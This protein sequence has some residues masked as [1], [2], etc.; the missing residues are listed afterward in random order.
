MYHLNDDGEPLPCK[1]TKGRCPYAAEKHFT[2]KEAARA[3]YEQLQESAVTSVSR[4]VPHKMTLSNETTKLLETLY[5]KKLNPYV[6][7]GSVRDS[8]LSGAVPKD[9]DIEVF[10]AKNMDHL[11]SVLRKAGYHVDAVGKSFGVLKMT[12]PGGDDIDISLPRR[13]SKSGD[14]HRGFDVTVDPSLSIEDASGRRDFTINALYYSHL[15]GHVKDPH[16]GLEDYRRE[17]LRHINEHF[18]EDP[19][20][21]IRGAQFAARF[22]MKLD[23]ETAKLCNDLRSEFKTLANER[24]QV[25]FEKMLSKGDVAYGLATLKQTGWDQDLK[26]DKLP[27][28]TSAEANASI[29]R[30]KNFGEDSTVFGAATI[31]KASEK[32]DRRFI[33]NYMVTGEKRQ[34]KADALVKTEGPKSSSKRDVKAWARGIGRMG[35]TAQDYYI[36]SGDESVRTAAI[37]AGTFEAPVPDILTGAKVLEHSART[38]GPWMGKLLREASQAQDEEVFT[39]DASARVWLQ[40]KLQEF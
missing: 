14:G 40:K 19:L 15:E 29:G 5:A 28:S 18:A 31:L 12:L 3:A 35:L 13:D 11:E 38:P 39:N 22:K 16:G 2:S 1:A 27:T 34:R 21:V 17:Q 10:E 24:L 20:R 6:V 9:I 23:P 8:I 4:S 26:L 30:A 7:G 25:E 33:A 32:A 36:F 37:K